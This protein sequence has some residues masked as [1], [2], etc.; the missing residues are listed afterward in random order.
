MF[1]R[2]KSYNLRQKAVN[3]LYLVFMAFL[4]F[5][6]PSEFVDANYKTSLTSE[7]AANTID[8]LNYINTLFF[9]DVL[10]QNPLLYSEIKKV[11]SDIEVTSVE[12]VNELDLIHN[13]LLLKNGFDSLMGYPKNG[14]SDALPED[15]LILN[16]K[17][18]SI[19]KL[20]NLY[21]KKILEITGYKKPEDLD[22]I[23]PTSFGA[24]SST[25]YNIS[26]SKFLFHHAPLNTALLNLK[27]LKTQ[28]VMLKVFVMQQYIRKMAKENEG[29]GDA[30]FK[31][32][33]TKARSY[34]ANKFPLSTFSPAV[35]EQMLLPNEQQLQI[36][37][38]ISKINDLS[39][40]DNSQ[41]VNQSKLYVY[42]QS[43][44]IYPMGKPIEFQV[45]FDSTI[46]ENAAITV[47][48]GVTTE[49][50]TMTQNGVFKY[51]PQQKGRYTFNFGSENKFIQKNIRVLDVEPIIMNSSP[52]V[53][54]IGIDNPLEIK[55]T[56]F[57]D[58]EN[59]S[60]NISNG[61]IV[62][63]GNKF[64]ARVSQTGDIIVDIF[65]KMPYGTVKLA[66]KKFVARE[67][68][69]P[70]TFF[71]N[72]GNGATIDL[73]AAKRIKQLSVMSDEKLI[74]DKNYIGAFDFLI[75]DNK[76]IA[77]KSEIHNNGAIF[78]LEVLDA[79]KTAKSGDKLLF[80]NIEVKSVLG[81]N[82]TLPGCIIKIR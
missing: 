23:L 66:S 78:K 53:L 79:L 73:N 35:L 37:S 26:R 29:N 67:L 4:F 46:Q 59:L 36:D 15:E 2:S 48:N 81:S 32:Y 13:N 6:I 16:N 41:S 14:R 50:F 62:K 72:Y 45:F 30:F 17:A 31:N 40:G 57:E 70:Y 69:N 27:E 24:S 8:K 34:S 68:Q 28:V 11:F 39:Q 22:A 55:I 52:P 60:A 63:K 61:I 43:D 42:S 82:R 33:L 74:N 10:E 58:Y 54:F 80:Y 77:K 12:T 7:D 65:A 20:L 9:L 56:E 25:D 18:D 64:Y 47:N 1:N 5:L 76:G 49:Q 75:I 38:L 71:G 44:T 3:L 51:I 19:F 21:K